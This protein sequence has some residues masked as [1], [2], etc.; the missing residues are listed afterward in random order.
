MDGVEV[1]VVCPSYN[2]EESIE[3][4]VETVIQTLSDFLPPHSYEVI[5]AEEGCYN[6]TPVIATRF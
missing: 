3:D 6:R 5:I 4:T 2:E 1:S